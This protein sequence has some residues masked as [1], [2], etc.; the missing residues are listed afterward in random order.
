MVALHDSAGARLVLDLLGLTFHQEALS[1]EHRKRRSGL[2]DGADLDPR[3]GLAPQGGALVHV[4][5]FRDP[6]VPECA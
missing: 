5:G 2:I 1:P 6:Y 3:R 4:Q